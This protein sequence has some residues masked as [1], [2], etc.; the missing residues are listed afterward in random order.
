M[1][2]LNPHMS[3]RPVD[4]PG[5]NRRWRCTYCG[6]VGLLDELRSRACTYVYPPCRYCGQT[7]ECALDCPGIVAAFS[8]K[9]AKVV[10]EL[11]EVTKR[12]IEKVGKS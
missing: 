7:P 10:G 5:E 11:P 2:K 9:G 3:L 8:A 12:A 6:D 4:P 1:S